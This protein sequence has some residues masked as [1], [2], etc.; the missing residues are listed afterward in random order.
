MYIIR[1]SMRSGK[2]F[3]FVISIA[4]SNDIMYSYYETVKTCVPTPHL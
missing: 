2:D 4:S 3:V 1:V